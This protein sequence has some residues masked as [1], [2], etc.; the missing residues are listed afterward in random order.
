MKRLFWL[1]YQYFFLGGI[2][3]SPARN[4][5]NVLCLDGVRMPSRPVGN[6]K[7]VAFHTIK[8]PLGQILKEFTS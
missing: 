7:I 6:N 8:I 5:L 4:T 3:R 2:V 1:E